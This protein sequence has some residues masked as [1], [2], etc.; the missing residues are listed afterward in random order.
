MTRARKLLPRTVNRVLREI[1]RLRNTITIGLLRLRGAEIGRGA[2]IGRI[3]TER[4]EDAKIG[5]LCHLED[6]VR[7]RP[8]GPWPVSGIEIG[9]NTFIGHST[10]I[11]VGS[12]FRIGRDRLVAPMC[13]FTDARHNSENPDTPSRNKARPIRLSKSATACRSARLA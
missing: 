1:D 8:D 5:R 9:E 3:R 4:P 10:Q 7:L 2:L 13:L 6:S 12:R 11:N